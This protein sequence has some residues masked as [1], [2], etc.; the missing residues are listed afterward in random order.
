M[1]TAIALRTSGTTLTVL[2]AGAAAML[3]AAKPTPPVTS[4]STTMTFRCYS[5]PAVGDEDACA[6]SENTVQPNAD[7]IGDEGGGF[8]VG[9][10]G[11]V[12]AG[13][14]FTAAGR[15][16]QVFLHEAINN[17]RALECGAPG[18][19]AGCNPGPLLPFDGT[20]GVF[21]AEMS[22]KVLNASATAP[23]PGP[24]PTLEDASLTTMACN[25]P[26]LALAQITLRVP[27]GEGH[28]GLNFNKRAYHST[29]ATIT[30]VA[31]ATW[32][33]EAGP[34]QYAEL[35]SFGH[36][37]IQGKKGPSH[38]GRY[39]APFKL[40]IQGNAPLPIGTTTC[41]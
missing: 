1:M 40:T 41:P 39:V 30:R 35:V 19:V 4:M 25:V 2:I 31:T 3:S 8:Y 32:V 37:N 34:A 16:L 17:S 14:N 29:G 9:S 7:H 21:D 24:D 18:V 27:G 12:A 26:R 20:S 10:M 28:W 22:V 23:S 11:S 15:A 36:S 5:T 33:V 6:V 13:A 38:E